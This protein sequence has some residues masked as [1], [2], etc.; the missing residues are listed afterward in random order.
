MTTHAADRR[1]RTFPAPTGLPDAGA[2]PSRPRVA[3]VGGGIAG[4]AAATGLAER[5]V[6]VEVIEREP[7]LGGRVGGWTERDGGVDLAM[8]RGFHAFFRQYYNLRALLARIDPR[9]RMLTPVQDYPLID[10]AG[11]RDSFR[12]LP[13]TPPWNAVA[14]AARSP[15]FRLRDFTRIDARAAAPL[16]AVSVPGTYERLDHIDA[17]AF[18]EDIR[19]P[20]AARHLAFE[21]F[22]RSFFADPA[23]LSAAELAT[24]FHIYFLGSAE[25]L[26]FDVPC[27]NYDAA[28]WQPLCGYLEGR[29]ARFRL[30]TA[31]LGIEGDSAGRFRVHTDSG[32]RLDVDAVVLATD[33]AGL[34]RI[35]AG[36]SGLGTDDWRARISRL[37]TA[38][39]FAVHR[40]WLDRPVSARRPAFLGTAGHKPL[41]NISVLERYE[42]EARAWAC[43]H[44]GSVV[45][46]HSY[47]LDSAP[48][49]AAALRRLHAVYPETAAAHIVH[50]RLL[51]RSDCPLFAPGTYTDRPAVITPTPGLVLAGDA[52]RIDLP[53]A[54]MERAATTGWCAANQLLK[55]WGLA[56]HPLSTVPT[57]GRSPLLRWL[58]TRE[59]A[60][61]R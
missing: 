61:R 42:R 49:R 50:E 28:L 18:L 23:K 60:A 45:E 13:R 47:A 30:G 55:R 51:H 14:F 21:V 40:F 37:R 22:S 31:A 46:L 9:L 32:E 4:L 38:P 26:I 58:A 24:M 33:V 20:E 54:L 34:Q 2:L 44:Q 52:I 10:G 3:V 17:A 19:F 1:R 36:S 59:G 15:T 25:G 7:Y 41:D 6:A 8:N 56:G 43:A 53:V 57:R 39:P 29:G 35:V 11:R 48:S 16:A 27:A 5:G 12:G